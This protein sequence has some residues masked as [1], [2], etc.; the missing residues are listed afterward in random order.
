MSDHNNDV[1]DDSSSKQQVLFHTSSLSST[2]SSI[3]YS[4]FDILF[5]N[6]PVTL[7]LVLMTGSLFYVLALIYK[8]VRFIFVHWIRKPHDLLKRYG[9]NSWV[10]ITGS[11]GGIGLG[12]AV[13]FA[14]LGF[15]I[16]LMS[17]SQSNLDKAKEEVLEAGKSFSIKVKTVVIDFSQGSSVE[18]WREKFLRPIEDLDVSVLINNV[19]MNSTNQFENIS[20]QTL[21]DFVSV[22]C[23]SQMMAT[24]MLIQKLIDRTKQQSDGKEGSNNEEHQKRSAVLSISSVAGQRPL[25][26]LAAYSATKSFN[27]FFS[28]SLALEYSCGPLSSSSSSSHENKK[29]DLQQTLSTSSEEDLTSF[30]PSLFSKDQTSSRIDVLSCRPGYVVSNMSQLTEAGGFVLD[31]YECARG[32]MEKLGFVTETYGDFR[33]AL[34]CLGYQ[35]LPEFWLRRIRQ[36]RLEAKKAKMVSQT[37]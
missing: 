36:K 21:L 30:L 7:L 22:N 12:F 37:K 33:H 8:N 35:L 10:V 26:Y 4:F 9:E 17:R 29:K 23:T 1:V 18:F 28:R 15:N 27:D 5:H 2:S 14:K 25:L 3:L 13:E 32:C 16:V 19:G 24:K 6:F 34:Y 20:D 31:K 11:S